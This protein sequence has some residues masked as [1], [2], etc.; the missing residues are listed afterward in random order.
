MQIGPKEMQRIIGKLQESGADQGAQQWVIS[1]MQKPL[2]LDA[3]VA[4]IPSQEVA[5]EVYTASLL[6]IEVD[7]D[8]ERHYLRQ[9]AQRTGLNQAVV[10][11][12]HQSMGVVV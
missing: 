8:A 12:I 6:A 11:Y 1:E 9:L 10:Q 5:A 3:F 2:D 4:E 7:T